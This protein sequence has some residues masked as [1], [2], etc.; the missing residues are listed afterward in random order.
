MTRSA[1]RRTFRRTPDATRRRTF[2]RTPL[3]NPLTCCVA[4]PVA[5]R[6]TLT[7]KGGRHNTRSVSHPR[8]GRQTGDHR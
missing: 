7:V 3:I 5:V 4:V 6:R 8:P 2:R 1:F